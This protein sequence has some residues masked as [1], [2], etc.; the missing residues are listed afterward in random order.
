MLN[1]P[2]AGQE[3]FSVGGAGLVAQEFLPVFVVEGG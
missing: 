3:A 2:H 1:A